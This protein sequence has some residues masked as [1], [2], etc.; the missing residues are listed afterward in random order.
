M[1]N[2]FYTE[3]EKTQLLIEK[4][5][6]NFSEKRLTLIKYDQTT[7]SFTLNSKVIDYLLKIDEYNLF[8]KFYCRYPGEFVWSSEILL[9]KNEIIN[10]EHEDVP[11]RKKY[12]I[13]EKKNKIKKC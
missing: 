7:F 12:F 11:I 6:K 4:I 10:Y 2:L 1:G 5:K 9:K 8:Y 3:S 13:F